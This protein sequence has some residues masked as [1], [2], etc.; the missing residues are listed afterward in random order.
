MSEENKV[1][2]LPEWSLGSIKR[3]ME[4]A[5]KSD[6]WSVPIGEIKVHPNFNVRVKDKEY[7]A[8][9]REIADSIIANGFYKDKALAGFVAREGDTNYLS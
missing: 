9:V 1:D 4:H 3:A 2:G 6:L 7:H 8:A 5:G